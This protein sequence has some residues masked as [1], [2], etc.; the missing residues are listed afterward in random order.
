MWRPSWRDGN[1]ELKSED[2]DFCLV[3]LTGRSAGDEESS[4][5]IFVS[6]LS[7]QPDLPSRVHSLS[8][9]LLHIYEIPLTQRAR[10]ESI[11]RDSDS[12]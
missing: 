7:Y 3:A 12:V 2:L 6:P 5:G 11:P 9:F 10:R 8:S 1:D 4:I